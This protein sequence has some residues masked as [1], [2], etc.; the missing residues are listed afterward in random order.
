VLASRIAETWMK[1]VFVQGVFHADPHPANILVQE[2][3]RLG[4]VDFGLAGQLTARDRQTAVRLFLDVVNQDVER[5]PRRLA[6]MG[7]RYP[8]EREQEFRDELDVIFTRWY[9]AA[10]SE[11]DARDLLHEVLQLIYRLNLTLPARWVMLDKTLATLAGVA[12]EVYPDFN[13]FETA[14]PY[15]RRLLGERYRPDKLAARVQGDL[16]RYSEVL[17]EAPFQIS[18]VLQ[19]FRDGEVVVTINVNAFEP[20]MQKVQAMVG[21]VATGLL[22]GAIVLASA[23]IGAFVNAGPQPL[24]VSVLALPGLVLGAVLAIWMIIGVIR[25]GSAF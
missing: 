20:M 18:D 2:P 6:E 4:L 23:I 14:G 11:I 22:A 24:G 9:G 7:V 17:L 1:M 10:L 19:E 5:M 3:D 8:R 25:S 16:A 21:R 12:A 13:V 15:A